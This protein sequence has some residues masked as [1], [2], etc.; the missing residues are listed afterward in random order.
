MFPH[1]LDWVKISPLLAADFGLFY[2]LPIWSL[3][4]LL[5]RFLKVRAIV[6]LAGFCAVILMLT[7]LA[8]KFEIDFTK[9]VLNFFWLMFCQLSF[10]VVVIASLQ[11]PRRFLRWFIATI[12]AIPVVV[13]LNTIFL[14]SF[15]GGAIFTIMGTNI[16][17][18][19]KILSPTLYCRT[20]LWGGFG[21]DEGDESALF[22]SWASIPF[23]QK[24]IAWINVDW[25]NDGIARSYP[26]TFPPSKPNDSSCAQLVAET[27]INE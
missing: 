8:S 25:S 23:L 16:I 1:A 11:I 4:K 12:L 2:V 18:E 27:G 13:S 22:R 17:T 3:N 19:T 7:W 26:G 9:Q 20:E 5:K 24:K 6:I 10:Y 15:F 14:I 21:N